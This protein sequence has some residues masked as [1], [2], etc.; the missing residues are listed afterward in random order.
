MK[1]KTKKS[2]KMGTKTK[3]L[4]KNKR[5]MKKFKDLINAKRRKKIKYTQNIWKLFNTTCTSRFRKTLIDQK[6]KVFLLLNINF[7]HL[8]K[9]KLK[10]THK[11]QI[12]N[13]Y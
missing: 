4:W 10:K 6:K 8:Q 11:K 7:L 5:R 9:K 2:P 12:C 13:Q 1:Q 3:Q